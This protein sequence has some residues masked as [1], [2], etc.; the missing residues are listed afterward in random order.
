MN[1]DVKFTEAFRLFH[2]DRKLIKNKISKRM[3]IK[4][5]IT[6]S[7][8]FSAFLFAISKSWI[9]FTS[10]LI[11]GVLIDIDHVFDYLWEFRKRFRVKEFFDVHHNKT[12]LFCM[13]IFHSWEFLFIFNI[14]AFLISDNLWIVGIAIG[15][16]QHVVLDQIF[17]KPSNWRY[18][19]FWRL[20]N[21]F[22]FKKLFPKL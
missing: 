17:N 14:Y 20:K 19:F 21:N 8:I 13:M 6:A 3:K 5:H 16:T 1:P 9:I 10:S 22:S 7:I 18:F 15:F 11:S 2:I 12:L 4:N